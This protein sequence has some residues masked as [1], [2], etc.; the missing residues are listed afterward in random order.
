[1]STATDAKKSSD[2][3]ITKILTGRVR[4][5]ERRNLATRVLVGTLRG[6]GVMLY[7]SSGKLTRT[8]GGKLQ[9]VS[10]GRVFVDGYEP[11]PGEIPRRGKWWLGQITCLHCACRFTSPEAMAQHL[12]RAHAGDAAQARV[13]RQPTLAFAKTRKLIG[14]VVVQPVPGLPSGRH[15]PQALSDRARVEAHKIISDYRKTMNTIGATMDTAAS[16]I[17]RGYQELYE[18]SPVGGPSG[19]L[20][21]LRALCEEMERA[22]ALGAD[23]TREVKRK[24]INL[25]FDPVKHGL[26]RLDRA[27]DSLAEA[28]KEWTAMIAIIEEELRVDIAAAKARQHGAAIP[29]HIL[30]N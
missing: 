30:A 16:I 23:A 4:K 9:D 12:E 29:D 3:S 22:E 17:K 11:E 25:G 13:P 19:G 5:F 26:Q 24:L 6:T 27:A 20:S 28:G 7:R 1:M 15:R 14:K 21:Q 8:V 2:D 10:R 18:C